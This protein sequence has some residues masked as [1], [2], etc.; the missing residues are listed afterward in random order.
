MH[1]PR[2]EAK[3]PHDA[4][5]APSPGPYPIRRRRWYGGMS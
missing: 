1:D 3:G 5:G 4:R 2:Q